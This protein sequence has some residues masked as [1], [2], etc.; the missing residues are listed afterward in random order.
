MRAVVHLNTRYINLYDPD[1]ST[2]MDEA[3]TALCMNLAS[4][5]YV[6]CQELWHVL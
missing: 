3:I 4:H 1:S 5:T 6:M 2:E